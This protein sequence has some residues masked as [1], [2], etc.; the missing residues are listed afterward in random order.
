MI[1]GKISYAGSQCSLIKTNVVYC[2][3]CTI[4]VF[5]KCTIV[6]FVLVSVAEGFGL[7]LAGHAGLKSA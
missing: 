1:S 6:T 7:N 2:I 5:D 4:A 3:D